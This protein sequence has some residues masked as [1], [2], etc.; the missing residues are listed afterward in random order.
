[1]ENQTDFNISI[2]S[3]NVFWKIMKNETS[4]LV[5]S[6]GSNKLSQLKSN[7]IKNIFSIKNY[8]N[9]YFYCFQEA[10]NA[11]SIIYQFE[12]S[13]YDNHIGYSEPEH[14]LTIWQNKLF[15]KILGLNGEFEPGRPF[16]IFIFRDMRFGVEFMLINIHSG[17]NP[18][19]SNT[20]YK[21][22]QEALDKNN[23]LIN[24]FNI[25]RIIMVG[26]FN[27]DIGNQIVLEPYKYTLE[28]NNQIFYFKPYLSTNKTCCSIK[29]YGFNK[30]YDQIIDTYSEPIL[31]HQ[32]NKESWYLTESSDHL[33]IL[34]I[35]KNY[36]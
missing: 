13:E 29:G 32:L 26:D 18:D 1:M 36:I 14:I 27:R 12:K 19:T 16:T 33:A 34:S 3:Y 8:Y 23:K 11:E 6:L 21:P 5:K 28:F 20:L 15:K 22:I 35:V 30:N 9:P 25:K 31:S 4:P 17:H 10:E 2:C 7:I 24:K